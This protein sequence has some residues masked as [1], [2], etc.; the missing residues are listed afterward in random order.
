MDRLDY[1]VGEDLLLRSDHDGV[2]VRVVVFHP[3]D[4]EAVVTLEYTEGQKEQ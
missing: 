2:G 3:I 4:L 1:A